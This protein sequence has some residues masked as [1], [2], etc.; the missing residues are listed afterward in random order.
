MIRPCHCRWLFGWTLCLCP[1]AVGEYTLQRWEHA[2]HTTAA[3]WL[4]CN[5]AL[6]V[7]P[8]KTDIQ[9]RSNR[10]QNCL[11]AEASAGTTTRDLTY[12]VNA[13]TPHNRSST[14]DAKQRANTHRNK[15]ESYNNSDATRCVSYAACTCS[16]CQHSSCA[17]AE[18]T[19][20]H[21]GYHHHLTSFNRNA[22]A[23]GGGDD[24]WWAGMLYGG[25]LCITCESGWCE[26]TRKQY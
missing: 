9:R 3:W 18:R 24:F 21:N 19:P 22:A 26:I 16:M 11:A 6:V 12:L 23:A 25:M 2:T 15:R 10:T 17:G 4:D 8:T 13:S 5:G 7:P 20:P 1:L 14:R